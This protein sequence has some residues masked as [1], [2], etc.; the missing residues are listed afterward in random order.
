MADTLTDLLGS[1]RAHLVAQSVAGGRIYT[2]LAPQGASAYP[3]IV[4]SLVSDNEDL[5]HDGGILPSF[6]LQASIHGRTVADVTGVRDQLRSLLHGFSGAMSGVSV[7]LAELLGGYTTFED[8]QGIYVLPVD[9][10]IT[11]NP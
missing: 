4:L 2:E 9:I 7:G 1:L 11:L 8:D 6:R 10:E 5:A 3:R